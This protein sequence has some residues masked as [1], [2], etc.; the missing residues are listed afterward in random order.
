MTTEK[1]SEQTFLNIKDVIEYLTAQG[2]KI[3]KSACYLHSSQGKL[4]PQPDGTYAVKAVLKYAKLFLKRRDGRPIGGRMEGIQE[5]R[6]NSEARKIRF[7]A[8]IAET[9]SKLLAGNYI[10]KV[11]FE[12]ALAQR[13]LLFKSDIETFCNGAAAGIINLVGGDPLKTSDLIQYMREQGSNWLDRYAID[14]GVR[15]MVAFPET[16]DDD[17]DVADAE[18]DDF[19]EGEGLVKEYD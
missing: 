11:E 13:A 16:K 8:D 17:L 15:P 2:F 6:L 18:D 4:L 14:G 12:R 10:E 9:R 1:V 19:N 3:R 5:E 7:Q